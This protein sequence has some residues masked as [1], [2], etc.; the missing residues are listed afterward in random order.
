M[1][2]P[3]PD[4]ITIKNSNVQGLGLFA[5]KDFDVDVILGVIHIKNKNFPHGYI[6]TALGAFYN[7]SDEPNCKN[8]EGFW[9]QLPVKYLVTIKPIKAGDELTANYT[10]YRDFDEKGE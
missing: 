8:T 3:L 2:R 6:R 5:T 10:L 4:G 9:H 7:H 1:Y